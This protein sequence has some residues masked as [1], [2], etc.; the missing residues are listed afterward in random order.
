MGYRIFTEASQGRSVFLGQA[1]QQARPGSDF[2]GVVADEL[3]LAA[4]SQ[5][6]T[7]NLLGSMQWVEL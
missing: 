7:N 4:Q 5:V 3:V 6:G 1:S 2:A